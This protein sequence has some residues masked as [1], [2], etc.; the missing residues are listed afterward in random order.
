MTIQGKIHLHRCELCKTL[1][2]I[3]NIAK[4]CDICH[5]NCAE[6]SG[7]RTAMT[8]QGAKHLHTQC[9]QCKTLQDIAKYLHLCEMCK[10][11]KKV[12][13]F[14]L[15]QQ[16]TFEGEIHFHRAV[17]CDMKILQDIVYK[18]I[19][20]LFKNYAKHCKIILQDNSSVQ[21]GR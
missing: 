1:Q 19:S 5:F 14:L 13:I 10:T 7:V 20:K 9:A 17:Q 2:N 16:M 4:H 8:I 3:E 12:T 18:T 11:L 21:R 15:H 6:G